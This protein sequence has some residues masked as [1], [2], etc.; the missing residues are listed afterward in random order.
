MPVAVL[1]A[2]GTMVNKNNFQYLA[3]YLLVWGFHSTGD[4]QCGG[5]YPLFLK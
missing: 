4:E 1:G 3:S 2:A 5:Q